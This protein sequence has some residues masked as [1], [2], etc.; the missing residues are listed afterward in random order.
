MAIVPDIRRL[1]SL[2]IIFYEW[3]LIFCFHTISGVAQRP[4]HTNHLQSRKQCADKVGKK[5]STPNHHGRT[6]YFEELGRRRRNRIRI[7]SD[8]S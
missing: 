7:R 1:R 2:K 6:F 3:I 4:A 8:W 5:N